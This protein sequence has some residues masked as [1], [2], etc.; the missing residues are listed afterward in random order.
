MDDLERMKM[1]DGEEFTDLVAMHL[2]FLVEVPFHV[3]GKMDFLCTSV[4][5]TMLHLDI[6][7]P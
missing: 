2:S 6:Q 4:S 5:R 1:H 3:E 7:D